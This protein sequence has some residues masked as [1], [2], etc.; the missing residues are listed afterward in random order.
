VD[1][2]RVEGKAGQKLTA[3]VFAARLGSA[4]DALLTVYDDKGQVLA[5]CDDLPDTT[6]ARVEVTLARAGV[7]YICVS[8][9]NDQGGPT[10]FYRLVVKSATSSNP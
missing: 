9:A 1:C 2:F 7:V 5:S 6:D 4:L 8:D 10:H 3:E